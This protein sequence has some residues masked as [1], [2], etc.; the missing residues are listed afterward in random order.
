MMMSQVEVAGLVVSAVLVAG[1]VWAPAVCLFR[2]ALRRRVHR[3]ERLE[4]SLLD[5]IGRR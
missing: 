5:V 3:T 4:A 1:V 2:R